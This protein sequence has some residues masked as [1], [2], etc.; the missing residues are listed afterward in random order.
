MYTIIGV[1]IIFSLLAFF[2]TIFKTPKDEQR[3]VNI[4]GSVVIGLILGG[5]SFLAGDY[6]LML[7]SVICGFIA[8]VISC[9]TGAPK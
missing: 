2:H 3:M 8:A 1:I 7:V 4:L 6:G 5:I 9:F